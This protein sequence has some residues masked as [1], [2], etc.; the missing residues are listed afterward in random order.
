MLLSLML[1]AG[2]IPVL[3]LRSATPAVV[4]L[5]VLLPGLALISVGIGMPTA[6]G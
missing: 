3:A 2:A 4:S 5:G 1:A 6:A